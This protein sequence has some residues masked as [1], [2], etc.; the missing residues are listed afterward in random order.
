MISAVVI[1]AHEKN[2]VETAV[3]LFVC[4][5]PSTLAISASLSTQPKGPAG[6]NKGSFAHISYVCPELSW[7]N[8]CFRYAI[9]QNRGRFSRTGEVLFEPGDG[10]G[11]G[12]GGN[13]SLRVNTDVVVSFPYV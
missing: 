5:A 2:C 10:G 3:S 13:P 11:F 4:F 7:Q 12:D 1:Y 8:D 6:E 9:A